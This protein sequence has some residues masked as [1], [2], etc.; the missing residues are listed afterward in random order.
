MCFRAFLI[1]L[2]TGSPW[3]RYRS[4]LDHQVSD[5][6][7]W[8][9]RDE[10]IK[11]GVFARLEAGRA[12]YDRI[13]GFDLT[14]FAIDAPLHKA[15]CGGEGTGP[16]PTDREELGRKWSAGVDTNGIPL[17][18]VIDGANHNDSILLESTFQA[19]DATVRFFEI[20][21][22][23]LDRGYDS[24]VTRDR[25]AAAGTR[26]AV[27]QKRGT[28][29]RHQEP[30]PQHRAQPRHRHP[31]SRSTPRLPRPLEPELNTHPRTPLRNSLEM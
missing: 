19:I 21:T 17:V 6:T 11:A 30:P 27:I 8:A 1:R 26:D 28:K 15:P 23:H 9:G 7:L 31:H 25:L 3:G 14:E 2:F 24:D 4:I 16:N 18:W 29:N 10:W 22:V 12:G 5:T 13:I 20:D